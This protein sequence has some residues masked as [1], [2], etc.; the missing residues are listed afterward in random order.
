MKSALIRFAA[1]SAIVLSAVAVTLPASAAP[2]TSLK[3]SPSTLSAQGSSTRANSPSIDDVGTILC[4]GNLCIQR[5]TAIINNKATIKAWAY[6]YNF[7]GHMELA[8]PDGFIANAPTSG[9]IF[10][11]AGVTG[12]FFRGVARGGGYTITA[13]RGTRTTGY[14]DIG[15]VPFGV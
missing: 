6:R 9:D 3:V 5:V 4:S 13:W 10:W 15:Q 14:L 2:A 11:T 12:A 8:G 7:T 1:A